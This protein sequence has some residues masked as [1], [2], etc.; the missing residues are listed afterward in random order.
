MSHSMPVSLLRLH[1][2]QAVSV[3]GVACSAGHG[4][5]AEPVSAHVCVA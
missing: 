3:Y 4:K 1:A 2:T 5:E